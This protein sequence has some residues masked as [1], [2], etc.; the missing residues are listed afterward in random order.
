MT[1]YVI[2][3]RWGIAPVPYTYTTIRT[4]HVLSQGREVCVTRERRYSKRVA[5]SGSSTAVASP[6]KP[7]ARPEKAAA[8]SPN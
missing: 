7:M 4:N 2:T 1:A 8:V 5:I 6:F 3:S